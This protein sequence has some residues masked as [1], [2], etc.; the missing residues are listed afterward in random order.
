MPNNIAIFSEYLYLSSSVSGTFIQSADYISM[1]SAGSFTIN[2]GPKTKESEKIY[3]L[4]SPN[5]VLGYEKDPTYTLESVV[6]SDQLIDV[7][8]QMLSI[9]NDITNNSNEKKYI[10][11]EISLLSTQLDKIK[12]KITKTY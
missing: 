7:L 10:T 9:M 5:I 11:D 8:Q 4:N 6:K 12:S 3:I 1:D 2:V